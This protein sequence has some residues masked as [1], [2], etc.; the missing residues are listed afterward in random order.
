MGVGRTRGFLGDGIVGR[1]FGRWW[2]I[3]EVE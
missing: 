2:L 3:C 1:M